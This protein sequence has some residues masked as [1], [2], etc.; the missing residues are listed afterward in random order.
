MSR[1]GKQ[2]VAVPAG[3]KV[4]VK[5]RTVAVE[6]PK[7]KLAW[8]HHSEVKV[9]VADARVTVDRASGSKLAH[10][11]HG[12]TRQLIQNMVTGVS[13]GFEKQLD[14]VGVGY[15]AKVAGKD[16][17]LQIGFCHDVKMTPPANVEIEVPQPTRIVIKGPDRQKVG[18]F[19]AEIRRVRPPEPY[20]GKGIR[21]TGEEIRRKAAKSFGSG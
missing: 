6:G 4:E 21:Y 13:K 16:L 17:V 7:G 18:Q 9:D 10:A 8:E 19:A 2:P 14:I 11:L 15:S 3:V 1:I 12:T 20:K 5:G